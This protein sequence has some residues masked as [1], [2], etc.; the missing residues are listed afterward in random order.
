M[1]LIFKYLHKLLVSSIEKDCKARGIAVQMQG[2]EE[3]PLALVGI[4]CS[5][6]GGGG[7]SV[8]FL[9]SF[10]KSLISVCASVTVLVSSF[11]KRSLHMS[12]AG[13]QVCL[14]HTCPR[15]STGSFR[16]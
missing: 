1:S 5:S 16:T 8:P 3:V 12:L 15:R 7:I 14:N 13:V 11:Q 4:M 6:S 10:P 2:A 9:W